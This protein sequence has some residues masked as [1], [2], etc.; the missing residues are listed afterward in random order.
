MAW[1]GPS[2]DKPVWCATAGAQAGVPTA[3][4]VSCTT[5]DPATGG[6]QLAALSFALPTVH[7]QT[8]ASDVPAARVPASISYQ[9]FTN[10][11]ALGQF[12]TQQYHIRTAKEL[13]SCEVCHR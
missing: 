5:Q 13:S 12:L 8:T 2:S 3:Q 9:K 11:A 7:A 1:T 4:S 6:S 10:Q